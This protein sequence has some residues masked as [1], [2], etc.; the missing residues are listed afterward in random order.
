MASTGQYEAFESATFLGKIQTTD[1]TAEV[2]L[3]G[4]LNAIRL[5][6]GKQK[7]DMQFAEIARN[8]AS[9]G[10]N[11][12][13]P[14]VET[15]SCEAE[16][17]LVGAAVI[18]AAPII[19]PLLQVCGH[20][21]VLTPTTKAEWNPIT[22]GIKSLTG[23]Y[24]HGNREVKSYDVRGALN[25]LSFKINDFPKSSLSLTGR[26]TTDVDSVSDYAGVDF[27]A[28]QDPLSI[29]TE[30]FL[31]QLNGINLDCT[32]FGVQFNREV[33]AHVNSEAIRTQNKKFNTGFTATFIRPA[34]A[35][36]N[37]IALRKAGTLMNLLAS[38]TTTPAGRNFS[39]LATKAQILQVE[40]VDVDG[41]IGF[42]VT[43]KLTKFNDGNNDYIL[44]AD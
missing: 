4:A 29:I 28:V 21:S 12:S 19:D 43:G 32:E 16:I 20:A 42:Q 13:I 23:W 24:L 39:V 5:V 33:K 15:W 25:A 6:N 3:T 18:G 2:G 31:L 22:N 38:V 41:Y 11:P 40:E 10:A 17:E 44:R 35:T 30:T 7:T 27:S 14:G 36:F 34:Y 26:I 8:S 9:S 37:P 1:G